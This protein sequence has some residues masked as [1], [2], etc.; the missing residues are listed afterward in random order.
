MRSR[1]LVYEQL[2]RILD[3]EPAHMFVASCF[4]P[5]ANKP[6]LYFNWDLIIG[7]EVWRLFT[8]FLY[9]GNFSVDFIFHMFFLV[10]YVRAFLFPCLFCSVRVI[11][12]VSP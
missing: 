8:N 4:L 11:L 7:G 9:F 10:R 2:P 12:S 1:V 3:T 5:W 6:Q